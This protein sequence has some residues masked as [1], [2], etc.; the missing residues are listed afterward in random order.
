MGAM[1]EPQNNGPHTLLAD[2]INDSQTSITVADAT[3]LPAAP[4]V[5]TIGTEEDAELVLVESK[6]GNILTVQR[7]FNGTTPKA[8][9]A[10][11]WIYRA[12]T[13]QDIQ[14][15]Q[16]RAGY[17]VYDL[18][19][20][21]LTAMNTAA[22]AALYADGARV[23]KVTNGETVVLLTLN[24]EGATQ[25]AGGETPRNLLDNSDFTNP[26]NQRGQTSYTETGYTID[27]WNAYLPSLVEVN[28]NYISV[29]GSASANTWFRQYINSSLL[30]GKALTL[31]V[32]TSDGNIYLATGTY[33]A[34]NP[35]SETT[36]AL[37][38]A[39]NFNL[40][41]SAQTDKGA[42][43]LKLYK[44]ATVN[45]EWAA[46]YKG[47]YTA[48]TL[49]PYV[50]K[51]N[52]RDECLRYR[53]PILD[54]GYAGLSFYNGVSST[55]FIPTPSPMRIKPSLESEANEPGNWA[56]YAAGSKVVP[57][58]VSVSK[59]NESGVEI[60]FTY[61]ENAIAGGNLIIAFLSKTGGALNS[62]L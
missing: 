47:S 29:V 33:P 11:T 17:I 32:K 42:A 57:T 51:E 6:T 16:K 12:I 45:C 10:E 50:P 49:P 18:T 46:L 9:D 20:D 27:R 59:W 22:R 54:A 4:N 14:E 38:D 3:I 28:P 8:W 7:G 31:A 61:A 53:L 37:I 52:E 62:E 21:E 55:I 58:A 35:T 15:L 39:E 36:V 25:W 60:K 2:T 40:Y 24:A 26:V 13:A 1:Y 19:A 48:D 56:V 44:G 34:E 23:L 5:L 41:I 43:Q 30:F